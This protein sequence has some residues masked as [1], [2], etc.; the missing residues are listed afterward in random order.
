[1]VLLRSL[2]LLASTGLSC[3][4]VSIRTPQAQFS[5]GANDSLILPSIDAYIHEILEASGSPGGLGVA[6]VSKS[7]DGGWTVETKGYGNATSN[8]TTVDDRTVFAIG[9]NSKVRWNILPH[10]CKC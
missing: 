1:M 5:R 7:A 10:G 2:A 8:G 6:V 3:A 4:F 9:S